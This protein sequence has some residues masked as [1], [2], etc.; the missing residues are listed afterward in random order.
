MVKLKVAAPNPNPTN[1][2]SQTKDWETL[3]ST[4]IDEPLTG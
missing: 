3:L 1:E 2:D 4:L